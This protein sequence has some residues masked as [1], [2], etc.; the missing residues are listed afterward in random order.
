M[1]LHARVPDQDA[2]VGVEQH[3]AFADATDD[4]VQSV[5]LDAD[6]GEQPLDPVAGAE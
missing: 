2:T 1:R 5:T 6:L 3:D 4:A